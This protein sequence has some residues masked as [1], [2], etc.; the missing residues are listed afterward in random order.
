MMHLLE[1]FY[2]KGFL[3]FLKGTDN[4][5]FQPSGLTKENKKVLRCLIKK[6]QKP[7]RWSGVRRFLQ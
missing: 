6:I 2:L 4:L 5:R 1:E 7:N 3:G